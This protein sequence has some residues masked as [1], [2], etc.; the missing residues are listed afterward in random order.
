MAIIKKY[1]A[2]VEKILNPLEEIFTIS[3]SAGKRF[4]Y[5]SGHFLHL[6]L[7]EYDPGG[8]WPESRCFSMQSNPADEFLKITFA[9]KGKFTKRMAEELTP[10]KEVWLKLP[11]GDI[12]DRGHSKVNCVFIAGGTGLTPFLSLFT[13]SSFSEY[14]FPKLYFGVRESNY[15]IFNEELALAGSIN[16]NFLLNIIEQDKEG[17]LNI[18]NIYKENPDSVFFISGPPVMIKNF[19]SYLLGK[20]IPESCVLTDDWE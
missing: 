18:E 2:K 20:G 14:S 13:D 3:F 12:F 9:A 5:N 17:I 7:D 6:A 8:Q 1:K 11:Y 15:N 16:N 19:K 4:T 10:G